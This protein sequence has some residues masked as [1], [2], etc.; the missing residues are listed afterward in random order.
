MFLAWRN[1]WRSMAD[2]AAPCSTPRPPRNRPS[3][4]A[5]VL[6]GVV[7]VALVAASL[8]AAAQLNTDLNVLN[9]APLVQ[10]VGVAGLTAPYSVTPTSGSTKSVT[11]NLLI[12]DLN[13]CNDIQSVTLTVKDPSNA[14]VV[15]NAAASYSTCTVLTTATYTYSHTVDFHDPPGLYK[16]EVAA[17]DAASA[18]GNNLLEVTT[19]TVAELVAINPSSASVSFGSGLAPAATSAAQATTLQNHGNVAIDAQVSATAL[20]LDGGD[21]T[22]GVS[23]LKWS[24]AS[25]MTGATGLTGSAVTASSFDLAP[26]ASSTRAMYLTATIPDGTPPGDY[27]GTLTI[28]AIKST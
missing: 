5:S 6:A 25:N 23:N 3:H 11:M 13:G 27:A 20:T 17:R 18:T 22:I 4:W 19:F 21:D 26:G 15:S 24:L 14:A 9:T 28:G 8:P 12:E 16:I 10:S 7:A 2:G 1:Q